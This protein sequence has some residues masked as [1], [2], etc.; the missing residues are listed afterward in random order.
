MA[1][2]GDLVNIDSEGNVRI[3]HQEELN[4]PDTRWM[5]GEPEGHFVG[6]AKTHSKKGY[7]LETFKGGVVPPGRIYVYAPHPDSLDSRSAMLGF[8]SI[9]ETVMGKSYPLF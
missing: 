3:I 8:V 4:T 5:P 9:E 7:P 6:K 2:E 1:V